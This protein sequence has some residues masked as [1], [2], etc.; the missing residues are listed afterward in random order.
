[1]AE[2]DKDKGLYNI[3]KN[4]V[5]AQY[6]F[7]LQTLFGDDKKPL[8]EKDLSLE[9]L[10]TIDRLIKEKES[11]PNLPPYLSD[12]QKTEKKD[13]ERIDLY[14]DK[15]AAVIEMSKDDPD[16]KRYGELDKKG[17]YSRTDEEKTE[18]AELRP[19]MIEKYWPL[20]QS[21][22]L[23]ALGAGANP[24]ELKQLYEDE[25]NLAVDR[26]NDNLKFFE[27]KYKEYIDR[28]TGPVGPRN[29]GVIQYKDYPTPETQ[30]EYKR[31]RTINETLGRYNYEYLPDGKIRVKDNY[32]FH[33][34]YRE[35]YVMDYN[36]MGPIEKV[37][38]VGKAAINNFTN[39]EYTVRDKIRETAGDIGMA[40]IGDKGRPVNIEYDPKEIEK[41]INKPIKGG[42][43]NI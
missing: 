43:K 24:K 12:R 8:T 7:Y 32:D 17:V 3:L 19:K 5:P 30:E 4:K 16:W 21:E 1:M 41:L 34:E 15:G 26:Y 20:M 10:Q 6:R 9:E 18:F 36:D 31:L 13:L 42:S 11:K 40:Y 35:P 37:K 23:F 33:N 22:A 38:E 28:D 25:Y 2:N 39:P 27:T 14:K 29:K